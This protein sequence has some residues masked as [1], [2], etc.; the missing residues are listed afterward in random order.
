MSARRP[1]PRH[2][3]ALV[4]AWVLLAQALLMAV[5]RGVSPGMSE[6]CSAA[7]LLPADGRLA[8]DAAGG[9]GAHTGECPLCTG[10]ALPPSPLPAARMAALAAAPIAPRRSA[11]PVALVLDASRLARAP[12]QA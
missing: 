12:P 8:V 7:G 6:V 3:A 1:H 9:T 5:P 2:L 4:L 11:A 10:S